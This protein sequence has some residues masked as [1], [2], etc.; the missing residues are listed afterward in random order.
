[1]HDVKDL[2][3]Y[4]IKAKE[5]PKKKFDELIRKAQ[6]KDTDYWVQL[7]NVATLLQ[8][9][10]KVR[11]EAQAQK[12]NFIPPKDV[13]QYLFNDLNFVLWAMPQENPIPQPIYNKMMRLKELQKEN[14]SIAKEDKLTSDES[15][16]LLES[17]TWK[18]GDEKFGIEMIGSIKSGLPFGQDR[19]LLIWAIT[20]AIKRGEPKVIGFYVKDFLDYF[21]IDTKG[22]AYDEVEERC[23]RLKGTNIKVWWTTPKGKF[24]LECNYLDSVLIFRP[25]KA[26]TKGDDIDSKEKQNTITLHLGL[27]AHLTKENYVWLHPDVIRALKDIPG[28]LD[29]YQWACGYAFK[30]K[31]K[32]IPLKELFSHLGMKEEQLYKNKKSSLKKWIEQVNKAVNNHQFFGAGTHFS[33]ELQVD[34]NKR[35]DDL[36]VLHPPTDQLSDLTKR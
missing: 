8:Q 21:G 33:L 35:G 20:E 15:K 27:W 32:A 25:K 5:L 7:L 29:L 17:I 2:D 28:A 24:Q 9:E 31:I 12:I 26:K 13:N 10:D 18:R 11:I 4:K 1:M 6:V 22:R 34:K 3:F 23:E 19:L 36:L 14:L 16:Q 30:N